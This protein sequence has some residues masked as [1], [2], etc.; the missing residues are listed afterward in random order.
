MP[1]P[2][3]NSKDIVLI[4]DDLPDN[5][6]VLTEALDEA[7]Y[8]VLVATNG[9]TALERLQHI[10]PDIVLLDAV[11]P[12]LDGFETCRRLKQTEASRWI[13][14]VFMT[15]LT[16]TEDIV[17][18][19][20]AGGVDY[21]TKPIRADEVLA[22]IA[23]HIVNA[24]LVL[25]TQDAMD[26]SGQALA[27]LTEG[28]TVTWQTRTAT[29][30][31]ARPAE[32]GGEML[33]Q[34]QPWFRRQVAAAISGS[35]ASE[36]LDLEA[37]DTRFAVRFLG[38]VGRGEFLLQFEQMPAL[39]TAESLMVACNLTQR[40][41]EVLLWVA[42]GKTNRDIG[43]ILGMSPRTVNK[44]LEHIFVKLGVETRT[45]AAALVKGKR[46]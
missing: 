44:H 45:A 30:M 27:V 33:D 36:P 9:E 1:A 41:S 35:A 24:R 8:M 17:R 28:G 25:Q 21:V 40:E 23:T 29:D 12:G 31:F 43:E 14:V 34:I 13:P 39:Q 6:A 4:V 38:G 3:R 18:G 15:G 20:Q 26:R 19:F 32:S 5:L 10:T 37:V 46:V 7:G 16:E 11:M 42:Q 2:E 22:R